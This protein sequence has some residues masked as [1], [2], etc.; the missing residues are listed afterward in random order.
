MPQEK[1]AYSARST[2]PATRPRWIFL[3]LTSESGKELSPM[4]PSALKQA[5]SDSWFDCIDRPV[6]CGEATAHP[7]VAEVF[8][9]LVDRWPRAIVS[10][11]TDADSLETIK[12]IT[13]LLGVSSRFRLCVAFKGVQSMAMLDLGYRRLSQEESFRPLSI[14]FRTAPG[15]PIPAGMYQLARR[16][17]ADI[18]IKTDVPVGWTEAEICDLQETLWAIPDHDLMSAPYAH[19]MPTFLRK[20]RHLPCRA[21]IDSIVVWPDLMV[22][23]CG[24][25]PPVCS[26]AEYPVYYGE[27]W[28]WV[29][30]AEAARDGVC[31]KP[32]CFADDSHALAYTKPATY[33][34]LFQARY[35]R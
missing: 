22:S 31:F 34:E 11:Q 1:L 8:K 27:R 26:L 18:S 17:G 5:I 35:R 19:S 30:A 33:P 9:V 10:V 28:E 4:D 16:S 3:T 7:Q 6:L 12:G 25:L 24:G 15:K 20:G 23:Y 13:A 14:T 29:E 2:V 21:P 32:K